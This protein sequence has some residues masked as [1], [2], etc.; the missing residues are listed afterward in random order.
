MSLLSLLSL[1][2]SYHQEAGGFAV[3]RRQSVPNW[4]LSTGPWH[5]RLWEPY[6]GR[7]ER[8][9]DPYTVCVVVVLNGEV[10]GRDDA[11]GASEVG[12]TH[13]GCGEE[14]RQTLQ[15]KASSVLPVSHTHSP[16]ERPPGPPASCVHACL[17]QQPQS[18]VTVPEAKA[19]STLSLSLPLL[20][21]STKIRQRTFLE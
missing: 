17:S 19:G 14:T 5:P 3:P 9:N 18:E 11:R 16:E 7:V 2:R 12:I 4:H 15:F 10:G 6:L 21:N 1:R 8:R 20:S 13:A